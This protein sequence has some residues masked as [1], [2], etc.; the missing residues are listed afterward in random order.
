MRL[1]MGRDSLLTSVKYF[2]YWVYYPVLLLV[3]SA[4]GARMHSDP[5]LC[6][7]CHSTIKH[8]AIGLHL[9]PLY[10]FLTS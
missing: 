8:F 6:I 5:K 10:C 9:T 4:P 2:L 7:H 3:L 1:G